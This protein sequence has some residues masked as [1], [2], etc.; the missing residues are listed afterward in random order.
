MSRTRKTPSISQPSLFEVVESPMAKIMRKNSRI[1]FGRVV[2]PYFFDLK[3][4]NYKDIDPRMVRAVSLP[5][6]LPY[7]LPVSGGKY[8]VDGVALNSAEYERI[9]RYP[10]AFGRNVSNKTYLSRAQDANTARRTEKAGKSS[11]RA[12]ENKVPKMVAT[13]TGI[14]QEHQTIVSLQEQ[15]KHPGYAHKYARDMLS[16]AAMTHDITFARILEVAGREKGWTSEQADL[17]R[18][19]LDVALFFDT[20]GRVRAWREGLDV[21]ETYGHQREVLFQNRIDRVNAGLAM[22]AMDQAGKAS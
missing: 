8:A 6:F 19:S 13:L 12:L 22:V 16:W 11:T 7:L 14:E 20:E 15:A 18:R 4:A 17:A 3:P 9:I 2:M 5:N 10:A 21:A 1:A